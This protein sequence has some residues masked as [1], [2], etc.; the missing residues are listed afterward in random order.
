MTDI[1]TLLKAEV[2]AFIRA[3]E[4]DDPAQLV[5]A[6]HKFPEIPIKEVAAQIQA[7]QKAKQKFPEWYETS[8]IVFPPSLSVEQASSEIT[9]R[10]KATLVSGSH[11][12]DLTGG[13]GIDTY[14]LSQS[15]QKTD[16][17]EQQSALFELVRHNFKVLANT[18]I[19]P[20]H[21][22]AEDFLAQLNHTVDCIYLDPARRDDQKRKVFRLEDCTPNVIELQSRLLEESKQVLIKTAPLLDIQAALRSLKHV[23]K[24]IVI[25]VN[26]DCKE[27]L[28]LLDKRHDDEPELETVYFFGDALQTF[29]FSKSQE[30]AAKVYYAEPLNYIYEPNTAILKAGAFK[31][32]AEAFQLKKL[33]PNSQLYTST[34]LNA[35]FPGRIFQMKTI[36]KYNKKAL[37]AVLPSLKANLSTRNFPESVAQIRKKT[38]LKEGGNTYVF[39]TTDIQN[40]HILII[41]EKV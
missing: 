25:A 16:Y 23:K 38:G 8:G 28:Y 14:Y 12:L 6:G 22:N 17:V 4:K 34:I 39:A 35:D 32:I 27:V 33:H 7:R 10:Y 3:H 11:L 18:S 21:A 24:I 31:V 26:Q 36:C 5:L 13:M 19:R 40:N 15:F 30:E 2:Q 1:S 41:T 37:K 9:A 20:H 29:S